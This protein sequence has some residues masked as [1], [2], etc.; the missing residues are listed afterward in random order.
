[1]KKLLLLILVSLLVLASIVGFVSC[2]KTTPKVDFIVDG[3][4][5][6]SVNT[7][8]NE[9]IELPEDPVKDG[10]NFEGW[11]FDVDVWENPFTKDSLV[12]TK[13][14]ESIAVYAKW[15]ERHFHTPSAW[16][17]DSEA[18]CVTNGER[19]KEC[20]V[21]KEIIETQIVGVNDNHLEEIDPRVEPTDTTNGLTEGSHC[22]RC[23]K[24]LVAQTVIPSNIK[25]TDLVS[26]ALKADQGIL[27]GTLDNDTESFS[28]ADDLKISQDASFVVALDSEFEQ[29][30]ENKIVS[31]K[32]GDNFFYILVTNGS[33]TKSY[34]V[35]VRRAITY[36]V[37][38]DPQGGAAVESQTVEAGYLAVEPTTTRKG[39]TFVGWDY[40]FAEPITSDVTVKAIW[41]ANS[42]IPYTVEYY[43]QNADGSYNE[44]PDEIKKL[45][46]NTDEAVNADRKTFARFAFDQEKSTSSG[47]INCDGTL[48]LKMY[49]I[50]DSYSINVTV[51]DAKHGTVSGGGTYAY[52]AGVTLIA[53]SNPGYKFLGWFEN[54]NDQPVYEE[55]VYTFN[56]S[57]ATVYVAKWAARENIGYTVEYYLQNADGSYN[58]TPDEIKALEGNTDEA[59]NA[60]QKTF[61]HFAFDPEKSIS[62]GSIKGDG[63]LVLKMYY[64]RDSYSI[65]VTVDDAKHGTV[66]GGG[67]YAYEAGVTLIATSNPGYRFLGWFE[68]GNDQ[69]VYE[70]NVYTFNASRATAYVAKWAARED[71]A[72]T[73]EHYL[74]NAD[75]SYSEI[76]YETEEFNGYTDAEVNAQ[77]KTYD[78]FE[79]NDEIST[80]KGHVKN[81][82]TLVLQLYYARK[83]YTVNVTVNDAKCGEVT[84]G[85]SYVYDEEVTLVAT[86]NAGYKF[87]GWFDGDTK[88]C[89]DQEYS[90]KANGDVDYVAKWEARDDITYIVKHYRQKF[91]GSYGTDA[92]LYE[93]E[94]LTG[95][96]D[97][98]VTAITKNYTHFTVVDDSMSIKSGVVTPDGALVLEVYYKRNVYNVS[99][100]VADEGLGSTTGSN[101]YAYEDQVTVSATILDRGYQFDGWYSNGIKV[102]D[103]QTY[104]F[105]AEENISLVAK[106]VACDEMKY[107]D[108]TSTPSTCTITS[109]KTEYKNTTSI[110]IPDCVTDISADAFKDCSAL[111][112]VTLQAGATCTLNAILNKCPSVA[113]FVVEEGHAIYSSDQDGV[114]FNKN[115]TILIKYPL[116]KTET[117]YVIPASVEALAAGAFE[118]NTTLTKVTISI[119]MTDENEISTAFRTCT[120]LTEFAVPEGHSKFVTD[121]NGYLFYYE[122]GLTDSYTL[123]VCPVGVEEINLDPN[124]SGAAYIQVG[125][126]A[127]KGCSK[128]TELYIGRKMKGGLTIYHFNNDLINIKSCTSDS[129]NY[130]V[131][132]TGSKQR[133]YNKAGEIIWK[134]P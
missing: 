75:G 25:G 67:T 114:L 9:S 105:N 61:A 85:G 13:L 134:E 41:K 83:S 109:V 26:T 98:T 39:Y 108:F 123:V 86:T 7:K 93:I 3:E 99:V 2:A 15:S 103:A 23:G 47:V 97:A 16:I 120:S 12:E 27:V 112:T 24:V 92:D 71:I 19:H 115:K 102:S 35:N 10:F 64:I 33:E 36:T 46:G 90:F 5:Y 95:I 31:L 62:S 1:M 122:F 89:E 28:F 48:V 133:L 53:T 42:G 118:G 49:Y 22:S 131:K 81:D 11:F 29:I 73:V 119:G 78:H 129:S 132:E 116:G 127:F 34:T 63:T 82:G 79:L 57:C 60:E 84:G 111:K 37:S 117:S 18:T 77:K 87:I 59:V 32:P 96:T 80:V 104:V 72:Y 128:A 50:R 121:D 69:P 40:D 17:D 54:G 66:S 110:V 44:T 43:L 91:D 65:N 124:F 8:G 125:E 38:F 51:D 56:A 21:C 55:N 58:E 130:T 106:F 126:N 76:P 74:Q 30:V 100:S 20:T 45:E 68:N 52:E 101:S 88:V 70:E 4:V 6:A 107:F 94:T 14:T 113:N